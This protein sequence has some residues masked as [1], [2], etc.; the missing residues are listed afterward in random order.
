MM[1][2][3]P[4]NR[5]QPTGGAPASAKRNVIILTSGIS[6]SSVLTGLISRAGYWTGDKTHKKEYDTYENEAL[7]KLNLRLFEAANYTGSYVD[8]FSQEAISGISVLNKTI[9]G[10]PFREFVERCDGNRPWVWKDPRLWLTIRFW[11]SFLSLQDCQ[12]ILLTRDLAHCWVSS[13]LRRHIISYPALKRYEL[14]IQ[15]TLVGFLTENKLPYLHLTYENLIVRPEESIQRL[16]AYLETNLTVNDL[17]AIYHGP[18]YKTP[19]N[20]VIDYVKAALIY[21]KNYKERAH[22]P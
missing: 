17:A 22:V 1:S 18:L 7:I 12:F 14:S 4:V 19:R 2:S 15:R 20:S 5:L 11:K 10:R 16:N 3:P 8:E 21:L 6:G 9:N 13:N